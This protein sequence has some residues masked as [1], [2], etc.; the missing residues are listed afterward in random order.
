MNLEKTTICIK[1][2][3]FSK[4]FN[5]KTIFSQKIADIFYQEE[6]STVESFELLY[7][8]KPPFIVIYLSS[9]IR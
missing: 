1:N 5:L 3:I 4:D 6:T 8:D 7:T 9:L 2:E